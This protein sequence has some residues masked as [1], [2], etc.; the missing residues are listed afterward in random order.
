MFLND[1]FDVEFDREHRKERPIPSGK[2]TVDAVFIWGFIWLVL[3]IISLSCTGVVTGCLGL[4]LACL[5]VLYDWLHK[6][7]AFGPVLMGVCRFFL[8]VIAA[9]VA[10]KGVTGSAIWCGLALG[11]Y[12]IGLSYFARIESAPGALR[13]WPV[14]PLVAPVLLAQFMN[15]DGARE[16]ALVLSGILILWMIKCLRYVVWASERKIGRM[17]SGLLAGIVFVDW[18]AVG[19]DAP[20]ALGFVFIGC[21]LAALGFQR[22]V[23]AT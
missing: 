10:E 14:L 3:G 4:S 16:G 2:I 7:I 8:Y 13:Y 19:P 21:F 5:I 12:V 6:K 9:A 11:L 23:P 18:L 1:A 22:F 17:V 15:A 20:R